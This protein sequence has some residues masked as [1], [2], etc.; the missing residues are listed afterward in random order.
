[1]E[2]EADK[3]FVRTAP[4]AVVANRS[5][6]V[7]RQEKEVKMINTDQVSEWALYA[8]HGD[9]RTD[10]SRYLARYGCVYPNP[11]A[12]IL[13]ADPAYVDD[14][15]LEKLLAPRD[16]GMQPAILVDRRFEWNPPEWAY[17]LELRAQGFGEDDYACI[18]CG[19]W[20]TPGGLG[21]FWRGRAVCDDC[22]S[23]EWKEIQR[24]GYELAERAEEPWIGR[25]V[26]AG[27]DAWMH[28]IREYAAEIDKY[29]RPRLASV[30]R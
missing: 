6:P 29:V 8:D 12:M 7:N 1:V 25:D 10:P 3:T 27:M 20:G 9:Y 16:D 23:C 2:V 14:D 24:R 15:V 13:V 19:K 17:D 28:S 22:P 26:C 4:V 30:V 18:V 21:F 5:K 11:S